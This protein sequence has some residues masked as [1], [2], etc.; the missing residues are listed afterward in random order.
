MYQ[1]CGIEKE[2]RGVKGEKGQKRK[3]ARKKRESEG[4][5]CAKTQILICSKEKGRGAGEVWGRRG[6]AKVVVFERRM[7]CCC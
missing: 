2:F 4:Q 5:C 1:G 7:L 6:I 3:A